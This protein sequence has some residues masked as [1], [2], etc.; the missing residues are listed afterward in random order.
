VQFSGIS[1]GATL[2]NKEGIS[3]RDQHAE[4]QMPT[5]LNAIESQSTLDCLEVVDITNY[6]PLES[7]CIPVPIRSTT[8]P[9]LGD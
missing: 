4:Q 1:L 9:R 8:S 5:N 7:C 3:V 2:Q 6:T